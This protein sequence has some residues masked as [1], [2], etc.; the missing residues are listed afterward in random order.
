L[1]CFLDALG[2]PNLQ[3][4]NSKV[5]EISL[6]HDRYFSDKEALSLTNKSIQDEERGRP[7]AT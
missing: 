6:A 3:E 1:S 7:H 5:R 2:K 4:I